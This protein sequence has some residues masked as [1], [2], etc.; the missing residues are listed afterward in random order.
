MIDFGTKYIQNK[1][2]EYNNAFDEFYDDIH[3]RSLIY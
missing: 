1:N 2:D 3:V